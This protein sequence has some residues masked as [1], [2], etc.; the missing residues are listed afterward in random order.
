[1]DDQKLTEEF[2]KLNDRV[3]QLE[4]SDEA[5]K[6][7]LKKVRNQLNDLNEMIEQRPEHPSPH[8]Q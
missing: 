6:E 5:R 1:M 3:G 2:Q 4:A 8:R 7:D